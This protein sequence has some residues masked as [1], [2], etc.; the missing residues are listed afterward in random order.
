MLRH[1]AVAAVLAAGCYAP[2]APSNVPCDPAAPAC[3]SGQSCR[4]AGAGFV[5]AEA[6]APDTD[7]SID[8]ADDRDGDGVRDALD[9]CVGVAN[10]SQADEDRDL[11]G[12]ACDNCPPFANP[13][14]LDRDGDGVGDLCDPYPTIAGDRITLFEG[15]EG[16]IPAGWTRVGSWTA[17]GGAALA[18]VGADGRAVLMAPQSGTAHQSVVTALTITG[19][20]MLEGA[21]G[22]IDQASPDGAAGIACGGFR[23]GAQSLLAL[24]DAR[25]LQ[26]FDFLPFSFGAGTAFGLWMFRAGTYHECEGQPMTG[27]PVYVEADAVLPGTGSL[28]GLAAYGASATF[29]WIMVVSSPP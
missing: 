9:N 19:V 28:V 22:V 18:Q 15:F 3:P 14:Q 29:S 26:P 25:F 17:A 2:S 23:A 20:N 7:G 1:A 16:G 27:Q 4:A 5:C 8:P 13:T 21:A 12:D 24:F 11:H 10:A 6:A